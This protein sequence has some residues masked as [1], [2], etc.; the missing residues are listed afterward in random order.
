MW[1]SDS[2]NMRRCYGEAV[3]FFHHLALPLMCSCAFP[4]DSLLH[5]CFS[6]YQ[7]WRQFQLQQ[8]QNKQFSE[9]DFV[10]IWV[11]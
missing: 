2:N 11:T 7:M 1:G 9:E 8:Q 10:F 3:M 5:F 4:L 6:V